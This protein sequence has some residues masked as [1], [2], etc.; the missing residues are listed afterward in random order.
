MGSH[1]F[2][3]HVYV[4]DDVVVYLLLLCIVV[5]GGGIGGGSRLMAGRWRAVF[6]S[7]FSFLIHN[8]YKEMSI[9]FWCTTN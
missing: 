8:L 1:G 7:R 9:F 3:V 2:Y 4:Y 5:G 6:L